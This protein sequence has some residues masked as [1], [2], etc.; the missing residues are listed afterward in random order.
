MKNKG[1]IREVDVVRIRHSGWIWGLGG[2]VLGMVLTGCAGPLEQA[3][4]QDL[5][6]TFVG[7]RYLANAY[8]G[9]RHHLE[10]T[11]NTV[12]GRH[13]IGVFIDQSL[14][15][16]YETDASFSS[17]NAATV[18]RLRQLDR[19][20]DMFTFVQGISPG[21]LVSITRLVDKSDRLIVEVETLE[22][23]QVQK[24][25]GVSVGRRPQPRASRI[26]LIFGKEGMQNL[27][28]ELLQRMLDTL[29]KPLPVL[30]TEAQK[31]EF[32]LSHFP[33]TSLSDLM[34]LTGWSEYEVLMRYYEGAL[35]RGEFTP[36]F[37]QNIADMLARQYKPWLWNDG[38]LVHDVRAGDHTLV[39]DCTIQEMSQSVI[40]HSPELRAAFLFFRKVT[41][42]LDSL[43]V[44]FSVLNADDSL[45]V[46][47]T[48]SYLYI[49]NFGQIFPEETTFRFQATDVMQFA[50]SN[51][52]N[53]ELADRT[54]IM[55]NNVPVA[56]SLDALEAVERIR[57]TV[58][59]SWKEVEVEMVDW[60]YEED[61]S[62]DTVVIRGEVRNTGTW[63]A[64]DV[65]ISVEGYNKYGTVAIEESKTLYG[66]LK[67]DDLQSFELTIN[68]TNVE[69]LSRPH[70][71]W[72][73]VD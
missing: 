52:D 32:V 41:Y 23:Y 37:Q 73:A 42:L 1:E 12:E 44:A 66:F 24:T 27:D 59:T 20:L 61:N 35:S 43:R 46:L 10:Y 64:E 8:L 26:H 15:P 31:T 49:D 6:A 54:R 51:I 28:L 13:P 48:Y 33:N 21:Q 58:P 34:E 3:M 39:L 45:E 57:L 63:L 4:R 7:Q 56:I 72:Q 40:Y 11:N 65:T 50:I 14:V 67:P 19:D 9:S 60:W 68:M 30:S 29:L 62:E 2:I 5:N 17:G 71:T 38:I 69:R 55:V 16:W 47:I 53:Q 22:R 25:Y 18:D 70:L 36:V